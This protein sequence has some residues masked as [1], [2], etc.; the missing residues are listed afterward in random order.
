MALLLTGFMSIAGTVTGDIGLV[1]VVL[2]VNRVVHRAADASTPVILI[3]RNETTFPMY[4]RDWPFSVQMENVAFGSLTKNVPASGILLDE[5][6]ES[7]ATHV[8]N[9]G[10]STSWTWDKKG[11]NGVFLPSGSYRFV[12]RLYGSPAMEEA[13][14]SNPL[15]IALT[16]T[17]MLAGNHPFTMAAGGAWMYSTADH[18]E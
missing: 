9:P 11:A 3:L 6:T 18:N 7:L 14:V 8:L 10:Q 1:P 12:A 17:G 16:P 13:Y 2:R 4:H 15:I 5:S